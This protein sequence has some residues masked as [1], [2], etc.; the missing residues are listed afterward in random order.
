MDLYV[1]VRTDQ[2]LLLRKARLPA[3]IHNAKHE[4]GANVCAG[5]HTAHWAYA[6]FIEWNVPLLR[7][8]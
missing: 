5:V 2:H 1:V 6:S 7:T 3:G 8:G 4:T